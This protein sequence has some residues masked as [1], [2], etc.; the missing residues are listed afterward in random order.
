MD[1]YTI[2]CPACFKMFPCSCTPDPNVEQSYFGCLKF[3]SSLIF[4]LFSNSIFKGPL[5]VGQQLT[6]ILITD[7]S[8]NDFHE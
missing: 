7:F 5:S 8:M 2:K 4:V 3:S 1:K 6:V